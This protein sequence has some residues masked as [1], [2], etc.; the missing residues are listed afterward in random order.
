MP[1]LRGDYLQRNTHYNHLRCVPYVLYLRGAH[2]V[3]LHP[4]GAYAAAPSVDKTHREAL[5]APAVLEAGRSFCF[6]V[7]VLGAHPTR[8][9][10]VCVLLWVVEAT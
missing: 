3:K 5:V 4:S 7:A 10:V 6:R 8:R 2:P 1:R 9:L